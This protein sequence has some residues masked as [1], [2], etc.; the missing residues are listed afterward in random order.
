MIRLP[1]FIAG[2]YLFARKSHNVINLISAISATGMAL[3]TAALV[4]IL[5]VYNGFDAMVRDMRGNV[6]PDILVSPS[7]GKVFVPVEGV[8]DAL[9]CIEGVSTVCPVLQDDIYVEYEGRSLAALAKGVDSLY[10]ATS[11]IAEHIIEGSFYLH[12]GDVPMAVT[13]SILSASLRL[14][15]RFLPPVKLWYPSRTRQF[16]P[17]APAASMEMV[18]VWPSGIFAVNDEIDKD[19]LIIPVETMRKLQGYSGG[20]VSGIEIRL[21]PGSGPKETARCLKAVSA[22]MG[23]GFKVLDRQ[24][25]NVTLYRMMKLEKAAVFLIMLF[26]I[27]IIAFNIFGS[28]SM[29]IIEKKED[30][31]TL[32]SLGMEETSLRRV[33]I[34]EGWMISLFG[35]AVGLLAGVAVVLLQQH[36]GFVRMPQSWVAAPYPVNLQIPDLLAV[37]AGV[38]LIGYLIALLPVRRLT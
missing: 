36:F 26:V 2:R 13:G 23:D 33:F 4:I 37:A 12:H 24:R 19:L 22:V 8:L 25:Q 32:R 11:P 7:K 5:S 1:L 31:G 29:L 18:K 35:M 30:I 17:A 6:E 3:G 14:S 34:Y 27:I 16:S 20:E 9:A 10:E 15:P 38:S 28:L 21:G